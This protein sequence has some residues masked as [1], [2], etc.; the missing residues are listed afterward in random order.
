M[1]PIYP[2]DGSKIVR[3]LLDYILPYKVVNKLTII[4]SVIVGILV[5]SL[6]IYQFNYTLIM[7][8]VIVVDNLVK[9]YQSLDYYFNLFLLERYLYDHNFRK[10]KIVK[11]MGSMQKDRYHFFINN[12]EFETE[13]QVLLRKFRGKK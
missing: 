12:K 1:L 6:N 13:K 4:I 3:L 11:K 8:L 10:R 2:L 5:I 9:Y 7:I